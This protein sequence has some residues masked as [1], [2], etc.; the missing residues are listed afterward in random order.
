MILRLFGAKVRRN[1][2]IYNSAKVYFPPNLELGENVVVG[3]FVDLY[4]V[5]KI[6]L[7][8]NSMVSQ[9]SFLCTASHD[10]MKPDLPLVTAPI[11]LQ[12]HTWV[13][14][15][16]FVAMG[17][18]IGTGAVVGARASVFSDVESWTIVG[19]NPARKLKDRQI[20]G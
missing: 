6:I 13:C 3:P 5:D 9:Y 1:V 19:G 4:C 18:T 11:V 7:G 15:D 20:V 14:A 17:V 2:R 12:S 16:A 10:A 8:D